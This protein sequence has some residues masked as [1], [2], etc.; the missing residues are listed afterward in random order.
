MNT[1]LSSIPADPWPKIPVPLSRRMPIRSLLVE[2]TSSA[3]GPLLTALAQSIHQKME[4]AG[5]WA[6][7]P[8]EEPFSCRFAEEAAQLL[9]IYTAVFDEADSTGEAEFTPA[10]LKASA[11]L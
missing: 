8:G 10:T 3:Q 7:R 5:L 9:A 1:S 4:R 2:V 6:A 11:S